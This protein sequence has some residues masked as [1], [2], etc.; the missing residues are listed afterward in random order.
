MLIKIKIE[1]LKRLGS[2]EIE[3]GRAV[4]FVGPNNSGKTTA[5]QAIALWDL[6][7][8]AWFARHGAKPGAKERIGVTLNRRDLIALPVPNANLLWLDRHV[9]QGKRGNGRHRTS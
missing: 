5:L 6:G 9:R 7:L 3:L 8:K 1:N 4:V 2:A